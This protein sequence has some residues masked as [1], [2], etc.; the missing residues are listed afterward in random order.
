MTADERITAL[1]D[2]DSIAQIPSF[3]RKHAIECSCRLIS[4]NYPD[5][6]KV[7]SGDDEPDDESKQQMKEIINEMIAKRIEKYADKGG[8]S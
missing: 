7:F 4:R 6:Y 5:I 2:P 1:A 8:V 3:L